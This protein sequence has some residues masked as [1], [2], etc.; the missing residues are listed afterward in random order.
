MLVLRCENE[1]ILIQMRQDG[2]DNVA[3]SGVTVALKE[4]RTKLPILS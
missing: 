1:F 3:S 4:E 2:K